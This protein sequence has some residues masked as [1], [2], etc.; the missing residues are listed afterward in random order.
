MQ[1]VFTSF[2]RGIEILKSSVLYIAVFTMLLLLIW[3]RDYTLSLY[4]EIDSLSNQIGAIQ[5]NNIEK[6]QEIHRLGS[7]K[8][9]EMIAMESCG[10]KYSG[11]CDQIIVLQKHHHESYISSNLKKSYL[12]IK[13]FFIRQWERLV[14]DSDGKYSDSYRRNL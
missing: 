14:I 12:A 6:I 1:T 11:Y 13:E 4:A 9:I 5:S 7:S 2:S 8:R 3:Q 10:L